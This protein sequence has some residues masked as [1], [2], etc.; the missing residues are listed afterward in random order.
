MIKPNINIQLSLKVECNGDVWG[1]SGGAVLWGNNQNCFKGR[2]YN[3][4]LIQNIFLM[5]KG[6]AQF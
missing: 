3:I 4:I 6:L 5:N 1:D 2:Q